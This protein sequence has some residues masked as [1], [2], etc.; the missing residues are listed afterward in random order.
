M[1]IKE[2]TVTVSRTV[3]LGNYNSTRIEHTITSSVQHSDNV[4][5]YKKAREKLYKQAEV[6]VN[7]KIAKLLEEEENA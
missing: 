3:N 2:V 6:W 1:T 7:N 4:A 5:S